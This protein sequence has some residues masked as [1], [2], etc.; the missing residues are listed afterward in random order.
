MLTDAA[1]VRKSLETH[2]FFARIMKEHSIFLKAGFP[3]KEIC[4]IQQADN[5]QSAF[6]VLLGQ[7]ICLANGIVS[8]E[9]IASQEFVTNNTLKAEEKTQSLSGIPIDV[10]LT[11]AETMLTGYSTPVSPS[12][13]LVSA[14]LGLNQSALG[15]SAAIADFK[16]NILRAVQS[17]DL[18]TWN[19]PHMIEHLYREAVRYN[20]HL[21]KLQNYEDPDQPSA[22]PQTETFWN[23]IME[24][25][26]EFIEH[27]LDPTEKKLIDAAEAFA[28]R[29][30][31]LAA[32]A[33]AALNNPTATAAVTAESLN[34]TQALRDFK[35][36]GTEL[37]LLCKLKS[38]I[39]PL[40]A[41]H[42][43][44]EANHYLGLLRRFKYGQ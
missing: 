26:S 34:A 36:Q 37:I 42:V 12:R 27:L 3:C 25:H 40:L 43:T 1:Y 14:V 41:D 21:V 33:E 32:E 6:G 23:E 39:S 9:S 19:F 28:E 22:A 38:L 29:F 15:W 2:L 4:L 7:A 13:E 44:R 35:K 10:G 24:D 31:L 16:V 8:P 30:K 20:Q 18:F 17:C 11:A 5:F